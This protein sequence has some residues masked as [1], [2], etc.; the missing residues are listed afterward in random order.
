[1]KIQKPILSILLLG[2]L[3]AC[4]ETEQFPVDTQV[5]IYPLEK[6][7]HIEPPPPGM[8]DFCDTVTGPYQDIPVLV[9]VTDS[10]GS[11]IGG[12][13]VGVLSDF[14]EN[15]SNLANVLQLYQDKNGNGVVDGPSELVNGGN[16]GI[17]KAK[18]HTYNGTTSFFVRM[19][20]SCTY[21]GDVYAFVGPTGQAM[22]FN[23]EYSGAEETS[24][25]GG[26]DGESTDGTTTEYGWDGN[27]RLVTDGNAG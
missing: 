6:T 17:Y 3:S 2:L 5:S 21:R 8:I 7:F 27:A 26:S 1:V 19:N 23:V 16:S 14:A 11:P 15:T 24:T 13:E 4:G 10:Q 18:T 20:L 12:V 22:S 25:D 9:T